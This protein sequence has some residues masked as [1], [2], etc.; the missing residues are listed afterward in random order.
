[1]LLI[2][3]FNAEVCNVMNSLGR[4]HIQPDCIVILFDAAVCLISYKW[5]VSY[6]IK[7]FNTVSLYGIMA[8][9]NQHVAYSSQ[10]CLWELEY[11]GSFICINK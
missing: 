10:I 5:W 6:H 3:M 4:N 9:V 7:Q 2:D 1:M 11:T 8:A